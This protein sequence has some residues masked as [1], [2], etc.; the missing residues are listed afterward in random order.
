M[1]TCVVIIVA[2]LMQISDLREEVEGERDKNEAL[3]EQIAQ[4]RKL[5]Q[6]KVCKSD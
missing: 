4:L 6:A 5:T 1:V 3:M 2:C